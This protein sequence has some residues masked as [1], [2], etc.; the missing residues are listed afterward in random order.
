MLLKILANIE[1]A[2]CFFTLADVATDIS[3]YELMPLCI[4]WADK[5]YAI[6]DDSLGLVQLP[7]TKAG[8]I[9]VLQSASTT[10]KNSKAI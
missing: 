7:I 8:T 10:I 6:L 4:R 5:K 3:Y 1:T 9:L 2:L